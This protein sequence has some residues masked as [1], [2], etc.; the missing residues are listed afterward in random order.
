MIFVTATLGNE[1][2]Q[3]EGHGW[4]VGVDGGSV[5][6]PTFVLCQDNEDEEGW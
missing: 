5:P 3:E 1:Y 2:R 4:R 6:F